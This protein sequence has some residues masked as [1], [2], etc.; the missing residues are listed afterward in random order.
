[1]YHRARAA[2]SA[3]T[4][5]SLPRRRRPRPCPSSPVPVSVSSRA[6]AEIDQGRE[7]LGVD[8][9]AGGQGRA[10]GSVHEP[11]LLGA[12]EALER[13]LAL[14]RRR[15]RLR[16]LRV[17]EPDRGS[18]RTLLAISARSRRGAT[19]LGTSTVMPQC[20]AYRCAQIHEYTYHPG[21]PDAS[22]GRRA[23]GA[24]ASAQRARGGHHRTR[25]RQQVVGISSRD[26]VHE[27]Q[28]HRQ[29]RVAVP[30]FHAEPRS[31]MGHGS[32]HKGSTHAA[33]RACGARRSC[34]RGRLSEARTTASWSPPYVP[35]RPWPC[36]RRASRHHQDHGHGRGAPP[37]CAA[38]LPWRTRSSRPPSATTPG[39][40]ALRRGDDVEFSSPRSAWRSPSPASSRRSAHEPRRCSCARTRARMPPMVNCAEDD[41]ERRCSRARPGEEESTSV[42]LSSSVKVSCLRHG[43]AVLILTKLQERAGRLDAERTPASRSATSVDEARAKGERRTPPPGR[44]RPAR[45]GDSCCLLGLRR[46]GR[47]RDDISSV[48]KAPPFEGLADLRRLRLERVQSSMTISSFSTS[49]SLQRGR[50]RPPV[51]EACEASRLGARGACADVPV[52]RS[53]SILCVAAELRRLARLAET[54]PPTTNTTSRLFATAEPRS[55]SARGGGGGGAPRRSSSR[56]RVRTAAR[57][58]LRDALARTFEVAAERTHAHPTPFVRADFPGLYVANVGGTLAV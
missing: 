27:N 37:P 51:P 39:V 56:A 34:S 53:T 50:P 29:R 9:R 23:D 25:R 1:M 57:A 2:S 21:V 49:A 54:H 26:T 48:S 44:V 30:R 24:A 13:R 32:V 28:K 31:T 15:P 16:G 35:P 8:D 33:R 46:R 5:R 47:R 55:A 10:P 3:T 20:T 58:R 19:R 12:G 36:R 41:E 18:Q 52:R 45:R 43:M 6:P 17:P 40:A 42:W 11:E 22:V 38:A 4:P 7:R 14:R